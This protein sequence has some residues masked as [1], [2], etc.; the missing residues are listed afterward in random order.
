MA[1]NT[2]NPTEAV[3]TN[4]GREA[5]AVLASAGLAGRK[6]EVDTPNV[7]YEAMA[8]NWALLFDLLG[9]TPRMRAARQKWLPMEDAES[10]RGYNSRLK[11]SFLYNAYKDTVEKLR[12]KPFS[13]PVS[14]QGEIPEQ[15]K[16]IEDDVDKTG[17]T[18]TGLA[19]D[20]M[21]GGLVAGVHHLLVDFTV[22]RGEDEA[23]AEGETEASIADEKAAGARPVFVN[24]PARNLIGWRLDTNGELEQIRI[25]ENAIVADGTYRDKK[26]KRI[27]V[28][29]KTTWEL[30]ELQETREGKG[31]IKTWKSL[32]LKTH[33]FGSVPLVTIY[34]E[35]GP[36]ELTGIPPLEDLAWLNLAHFQSLS[37]QRNILRIIRSA[38]LF[39]K[40]WKQDDI[41]KGI[42]VGPRN[43]I[44]QE[45][46]KSDL[47]Y[48]EHSG[49]GI[50]AGREDILDIEARMEVLGL[51]PLIKKT[52]NQTA[53]GKAIDEAKNQSRMQAYV[54][55]VEDGLE[56]AYKFAAKWVKVVLPSDF[57]VDIFS[58]FGIGAKAKE[59]IEA[60]LKSRL[61]KQ[62]THG[63]FLREIQRRGLI[64]ETVDVEKEIEALEDEGPPLAGILPPDDDDDED[65]SGGDK[66]VEP[67][68]E[69]ETTGTRAGAPA[70]ATA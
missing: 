66:N 41:D 64:S 29:T 48:V 24:V 16:M 33:T 68:E 8:A 9:G 70:R 15:L 44:L 45:N 38:I 31:I 37:D 1:H 7:Q 46:E 63:T 39:G 58:D 60:L 4:A 59:D 61:A 21:A 55:A 30:F 32:G 57:K 69:E 42:V 10:L 12:A 34:F 27:R 36:D 6:D 56:R 62:I 53:T 3:Q 52:G 17:R 5:V 28:V 23:E 40:G 47:K 35:Q 43:A 20:I 11:R 65:E 26:V 49:K 67:E 51:Q 13:K 22:M 14:V 25:L 19:G 18:L 54:R 2:T 50:Q